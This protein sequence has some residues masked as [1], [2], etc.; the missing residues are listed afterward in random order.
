MQILFS[1]IQKLCALVM[2]SVL[3]DM[4]IPSGSMRKYVRLACGMLVLHIM[5]SQ[6]FLLFGRAAPDIEAQQ[7]NQLLGE[8]Q[9]DPQVAGEEAA[10]AA[11]QREAERLILNRARVLGMAEPTVTIGWDQDS[12]VA[13]LILRD[14]ATAITASTNGE[15]KAQEEAADLVKIREGIAEMLHIPIQ[16]IWIQKEG[17]GT[18]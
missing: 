15:N 10:F 7:W 14:A 3:A 2:I 18:P 9:A 17:D 16:S 12:R 5:V 1:L 6:V 13:G 8:M 11:Y 4:L